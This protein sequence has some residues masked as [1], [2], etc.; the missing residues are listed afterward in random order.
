MIQLKF[1]GY[2]IGGTGH[3][4]TKDEWKKLSNKEI[5]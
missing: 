3:D 2:E 4:I 1:E 5:N